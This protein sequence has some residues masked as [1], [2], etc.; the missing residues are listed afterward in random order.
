MKLPEKMRVLRKSLGYNQTDFGIELGLK[1]SSLAY[2][3]NGKTKILSDSVKIILKLKFNVNIEWM[4]NDS[5][6]KT[7]MIKYDSLISEPFE[8]YSKCKNCNDKEK[9]IK[10]LEGIIETINKLTTK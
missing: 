7:Q 8:I 6:D 1:Q 3:E 10:E 9:R 5:D 2:I 4:E